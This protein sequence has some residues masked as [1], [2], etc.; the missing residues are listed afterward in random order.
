MTVRFRRAL[1][2]FLLS[3][4]SVLSS[5]PILPAEATPPAP[6]AAAPAPAKY[7]KVFNLYAPLFDALTPEASE[8]VR[9]GSYERRFDE[10]RRRVRAWE[11]ENVK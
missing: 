6:E 8:K 1:P 4:L 5:P 9:K 2:L 7:L 10:A 11:K 3:D